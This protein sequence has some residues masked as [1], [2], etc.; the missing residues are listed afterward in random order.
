MKCLMFTVNGLIMIASGISVVW[1]LLIGQFG[2]AWL[3]VIPLIYA[4]FN[5]C[6]IE[7]E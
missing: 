3:C 5:C 7:E 4:Y 2:I 6:A 1:H